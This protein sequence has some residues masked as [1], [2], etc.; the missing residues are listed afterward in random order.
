[1][2]ELIDSRETA[3][4]VI[5]GRITSVVESGWLS[6]LSS[7]TPTHT[8]YPHGPSRSRVFW[9]RDGDTKD[10]APGAILDVWDG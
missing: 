7:P 6:P 4:V 3:V 5:G 1:M 10:A 9:L 2:D 8:M